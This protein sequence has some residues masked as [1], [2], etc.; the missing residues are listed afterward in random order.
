MQNEVEEM[1]GIYNKNLVSYSRKKFMVLVLALASLF[2]IVVLFAKKEFSK[3]S[4]SNEAEIQFKSNATISVATE[5]KSVL[6]VPAGTIKQNP[7]LPYREMATSVV[8]DVP[9]YQ[10]IEPPETIQASS[11]AARVM[12]AIVSG[13]LFDKYSPSAIL[14]IEGNDYLVKKGDI[15]NNYKIINITQDTVTV[16]LGENSYRAGIGEILTE[17]TITHSNIPNLSNKFGGGK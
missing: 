4:L 8:K 2:L 7:F 12:D 14:N 16:K 11:D 5:N 3:I 9:T 17:G 10:L 6:N 1:I 15:V 13:I